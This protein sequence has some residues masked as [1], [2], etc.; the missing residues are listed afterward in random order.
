MRKLPGFHRAQS[1]R[2][3]SCLGESALVVLENLRVAQSLDQAPARTGSAVAARLKSRF[4][5]PGHPATAPCGTSGGGGVREVAAFR[6]LPNKGCLH[7]SKLREYDL[8]V[9]HGQPL[10]CARL[11]RYITQSSQK[12]LGSYKLIL[13]KA[14]QK[15]A[16]PPERRWNQPRTSCPQR[17]RCMVIDRCSDIKCV[18]LIIHS[19][20]HRRAV[21]PLTSRQAIAIPPYSYLSA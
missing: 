7:R 12:C 1:H 11:L 19:P 18:A 6:G 20:D 8:R 17:R 2:Q 15:K 3:A 14:R 5:C 13:L 10:L 9:N 21:L 4:L 16:Q